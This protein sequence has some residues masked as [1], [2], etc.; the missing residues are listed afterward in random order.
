MSLNESSG[1]AGAGAGVFAG[2]GAGAGEGTT[3]F[4]AVPED[5]AVPG[6]GCPGFTAPVGGVFAGG[7]GA[8]VLPKS[9][10][11]IDMIVS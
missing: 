8:G 6:N 7:V 10:S 9:F 1:D 5:A 2:T 11:K 3:P 4:G